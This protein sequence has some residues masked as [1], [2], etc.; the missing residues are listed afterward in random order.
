MTITEDIGDSGSHEK[1]YTTLQRYLA[2]V[3]VKDV[4][5]SETLYVKY[6]QVTANAQ[7]HGI[8]AVGSLGD[9]SIQHEMYTEEAVAGAHEDCV[10]MI[11]G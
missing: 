8:N 3:A 1:V 6:G 4:P 2:S 5:F 11:I 9:H 10:G 7:N